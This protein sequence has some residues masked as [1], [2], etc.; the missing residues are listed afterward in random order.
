MAIVGVG[1]GGGVFA[2]GNTQLG[3]S[4]SDMTSERGLD[5]FFRE[6]HAYELAEGDEF[7]RIFVV[8]GSAAAANKSENVH[9]GKCSKAKSQA[10]E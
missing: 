5:D 9:P 1:A 7:N 6:T 8:E 4:R 10:D 2:Y 3:I